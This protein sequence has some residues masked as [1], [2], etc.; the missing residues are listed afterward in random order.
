MTNDEIKN[1]ALSLVKADSQDEVIDL[2]KTAGLWDAPES[3]RLYGDRD[4]NFATIGNQQSSP[5][6]AL[7]EKIV[8]SVDA[9]LMNECLKRG[10]APDTVSAPQSIREAVRRF[11]EGKDSGAD[12]GGTVQ[13][14]DTG[15]QLAEAQFITLAVTGYGPRMGSGRPCITIV[16]CG[17]GQTAKRMPETFLSIDKEN[18]LRVPF[19]QGKFNMG[20]TGALKFCGDHGLQLILS[21]RNPSILTPTERKDHAAHKWGL[22]VV[23]RERPQPGGGQVRNSVF[24][25]LAPVSA[26]LNPAHGDLLTFAAEALALMPEENKPYARAVQSGSVIKL[27][28]YELR[29]GTRSHALMKDGLLFRL[30]LL[31]PGIALPVRVHECRQYR[32]EAARSFANTLVGFTSRL[33]SNRGENLEPGYPKSAP[34]TVRGH[35]M[36]AQIYAFRDKKADSYRDNEGIIFMMNGQTHGHIPKTFFQRTGVKMGRIASSLIVVV[37]CSELAVD[38]REDLFMN[39]RDRLSNGELRK[40]LEEELEDVIGHHPGLKEL[41]EQRRRDEIAGRLDDSRPLE[42]VLGAILKSSPSLSQLFLLGRRLSRP[43]P[44]QLGKGDSGGSGAAGGEGE[45]RGR[46]HPTFFRFS[47]KPAGET[48]LRTWELGRRCRVKLETDV[49]NEYFSR[50]ALPG[51]Y[52]VEVL[53]GSIE[54]ADLDHNLTLHDGVASWS[55]GLPEELDVGEEVTIQLTVTDDV[56]AEPLVNLLK[57]RATPKV[58]HKSGDVHD[59]NGRKGGGEPGPKGDG[60]SGDTGQG[61]PEKPGG[62]ELPTIVEVERSDENWARHSFTDQTACKVIE[63]GAGGDD[64]N[65][66]SLYTFYVNVDNIYLRTDMKAGHEDVAVKKAKFKYGNV[67]VALALIQERRDRK[68][69][70]PAD[71]G[72]DNAEPES[73]DIVVDKTTRAL[74]PFLVPMIDYLGALTADELANLSKAGD[75]E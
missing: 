10:I 34:L 19:V 69:G 58:T 6:S 28:E 51:R 39:S 8:N 11:V 5:E 13:T 31:L 54:G 46:E 44:S 32:G 70:V 17:E 57:L 2:L 35:K 60:P 47:Q 27:Y 12:T 65:E 3:W 71:E 75:E 20:G 50:P 23:R 7:V 42:D 22:T 49:E 73:I 41:R 67:L 15:K 52:H 61:G 18:K 36:V 43:H 45:F 16:D 38:A 33:E 48:L 40:A 53:E 24:K 14:W 66:Q 1:L 74:S 63:D 9:R 26:N 21:R 30:E 64:N 55:I 29:K 72:G 37:D 4:G 68:P 56:I 62:I 59:P 25:Y